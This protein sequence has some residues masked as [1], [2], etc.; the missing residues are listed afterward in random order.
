MKRGKRNKGVVNS[1]D[2]ETYLYKNGTWYTTSMTKAPLAVVNKLNTLLVEDEDLTDKS[3]EELME[4]IDDSRKTDNF[5]L[6]A[7]ALSE[8]IK[9]AKPIEIKQLLPRYTSNLRKM[10]QSQKAIN[11][12][13]FYLNKY[14]RLVQTSALFTSIGA[15]YCDLGDYETGKQCANRARALSG[16]VSSAELISL[17]ARLK[18]HNEN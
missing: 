11:E 3:M 8:A 14:G 5:L 9:K 12:A 6:S 7:K 15:A 4:M 17:Y 18:R 10:G 1:Y 13:N 2:G 16:G